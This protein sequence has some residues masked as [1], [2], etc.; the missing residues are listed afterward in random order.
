[1]SATPR[2]GRRHRFNPSSAH[3]KEAL[4]HGCETKSGQGFFSLSDH[5]VRIGAHA[6][7][8]AQTAF[9]GPRVAQILHHR[10]RRRRFQGRQFRSSVPQAVNNARLGAAVGDRH[11]ESF[12]L[13]LERPPACFDGSVPVRI[14]RRRFRPGVTLPGAM[15]DT[16]GT[17]PRRSPRCA[18]C[19]IR[20]ATERVE[21]RLRPNGRKMFCRSL[22]PMRAY[23]FHERTRILTRQ[24][25]RARVA[26][27]IRFGRRWAAQAA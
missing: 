4:A 15:M 11:L 1:M 23:P 26:A 10:P 9:C 14:A 3:T 24:W 19:A 17:P 12:D 20:D 21:V 2:H 7:T 27:V 13:I 8:L 18:G 5:A 25:A 6:G 22:Q 16:P